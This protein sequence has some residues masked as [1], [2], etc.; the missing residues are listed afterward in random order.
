MREVARL[1]GM[2]MKEYLLLK[3]EEDE[4]SLGLMKKNLEFVEKRKS[5][6]VDGVSK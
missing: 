1:L 5:E 6:L 2:N 3:I 4:K